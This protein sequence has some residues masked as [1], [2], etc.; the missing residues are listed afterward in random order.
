MIT[1]INRRFVPLEQAVISVFDRGFLYGDGLFEAIHFRNGRP[2]RWDAHLERLQAG[3]DYLM[4]KCPYSSSE[5]RDFATRLINENRMPDCLLR[6]NVSRGP[7]ARR[8]SSPLG[9]NTPTVVMA[10]HPAPPK[11][12]ELPRWRV[13][14]STVRL[15]A[16]D[17]LANIKTCNKLL[18]VLARAEADAAGADDI[19]LL[20]TDGFVAEGSSSNVF[21]IKN[22]AASTPPL[23]HGIL[24]GVTRSV[25]F[26]LC[27]QI[28]LPVCEGNITSQQLSESEGVFLSLTSFGVVECESLDAKPLQTSALVTKLF[29][30]YNSLFEKETTA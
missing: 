27:K 23:T 16:A 29:H 13:M 25:I 21:W 26:E 11:P 3:L 24:P 10:L 4:L 6:L 19:I 8:G 7:S 28:G 15:P 9:A 18:Q 17:P 14:T 2:F 1:F 20:N 12:T 5:L 30:Q 22:G